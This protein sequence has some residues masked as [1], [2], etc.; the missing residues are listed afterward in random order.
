MRERA[1][2]K[3]AM[4]MHGEYLIHD[5]AGEP[6]DKVP[7]VSRRG[8]AF[9]VWAVL[10][11][12]GRDGVAELVDRLCR[13][14][15]GLADG[16]AELPGA[17]VCND[18]VFTQ[19]CASFGDD[20]R[21]RGVVDAMLA[22]GTAWMTGSVWHGRAVLRISV[23]NWSTTEDDVRRSLEALAKAVAATGSEQEAE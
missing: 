17:E 1:A 22:D 4:G 10:K 21:T 9:P 19:V 5:E 16:L 18:V 20:R 15:A 23:S 7:E 3:A 14:A 6:L 13:H 8:R 11:A 12:L 2:L